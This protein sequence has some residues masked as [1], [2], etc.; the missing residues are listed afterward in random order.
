MNELSFADPFSKIGIFYLPP[1]K[2]LND[3]QME[4]LFTLPLCL[5]RVVE[6]FSQWPIRPLQ[7]LIV[8]QQCVGSLYKTNYSMVFMNTKQIKRQTKCTEMWM[9]L[10]RCPFLMGNWFISSVRQM[11]VLVLDRVTIYI[12]NKFS[13]TSFIVESLGQFSWSLTIQRGQSN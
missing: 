2:V 4:T 3:G 7:Q 6:K 12:Y 11:V 8:Q 5:H 13:F 1:I 9:F 10:M